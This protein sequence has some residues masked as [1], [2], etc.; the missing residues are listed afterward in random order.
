MQLRY[1]EDGP[2]DYELRLSRVLSPFWDAGELGEGS[3]WLGSRKLQY[4]EQYQTVL[5]DGVVKNA[6]ADC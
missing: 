2:R 5:K 3:S 4:S 6:T 1:Q